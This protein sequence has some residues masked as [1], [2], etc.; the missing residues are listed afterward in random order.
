[1][2]DE[3]A[4]HQHRWAMLLDPPAADNTGI[5][6]L[7]PMGMRVMPNSSCAICGLTPEAVANEAAIKLLLAQNAQ[8]RE[9]VQ[10]VAEKGGEYWSQGDNVCLYCEARIQAGMTGLEDDAVRHTPDC[11]VT[12]ARTLLGEGE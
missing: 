10:V 9:I 7:S 5:G 6:L 3:I 12:K 8:L 4:P 2:S 1:M 11:I